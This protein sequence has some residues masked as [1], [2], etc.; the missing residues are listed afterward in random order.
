MRRWTPAHMLALYVACI[1]AMAV[2]GAAAML[3]GSSGLGWARDGFILES[4][5]ERVLI[6]SLVGFALGVAGV[7]YQA[8]LRNDLADP[9]LLGVA[10]GA[11]LMA[12]IW[13]LPMVAGTLAGLGPV[14]MGLSQQAFAFVGGLGAAAVVLV[15]AGFRR[16]AEP[17]TLVLTGVI[18]STLCGAL[19]LLVHA[20]ARSMPGS[21]YF[22]TLI[23]GEIQT[24]LAPTYLVI[25]GT[26]TLLGTIALQW[27]APVL[28]VA[29][30]SD[31]ESRSLGVNVARL[32]WWTMGIA[33][34]VTASAVAISGPIGFVGLIAPHVARRIVGVDVR[35][36]LVVAGVIGAALV[37]AGDALARGLAGA[38]AVNT[39]LPIGIFTAVLGGPFF[40]VLL[41]RR[42][43][44][45]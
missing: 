28:N 24:N 41:M 16:R 29:G 8:V 30:T 7:A 36:S 43:R 22:Q 35:V 34:M 6:G 37:V 44:S 10:S 4:R 21:G 13:R 5:F 38:G 11:S 12:Y 15:I 33:S 32:R 17:T 1:V 40:L 27:M 26:I 9:Y 20:L 31:D 45:E 19:I 14:A 23:V 3:V 18:V 25:A 42:G 2:V 39:I